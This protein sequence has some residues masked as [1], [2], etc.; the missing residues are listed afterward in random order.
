MHLMNWDTNNNCPTHFC[1]A[2]QVLLG[3][4][5]SLKTCSLPSSC[6][7]SSHTDA[8]DSWRLI[9]RQPAAV[10]ILAWMD[11]I[12]SPSPA[13]IAPPAPV[14]LEARLL[15]GCWKHIIS[16][17]TSAR[18]CRWLHKLHTERGTSSFTS[19]PFLL[20]H[21]SCPIPLPCPHSKSHGKDLLLTS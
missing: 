12:P 19:A 1:H 20:P 5:Y 7:A 17:W 6:S 21:S 2:F 9:S 10:Q 14:V 16:N 15:S 11:V 8:C 3:H 18:S 13:F 4:E